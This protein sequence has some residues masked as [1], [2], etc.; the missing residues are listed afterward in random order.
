MYN[1]YIIDLVLYQSILSSETSNWY[2]ASYVP[3]FANMYYYIE[4]YSFA[5]CYNI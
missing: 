3:I 2:D 1:S 4:A 5:I